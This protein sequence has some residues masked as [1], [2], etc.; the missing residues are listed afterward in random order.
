MVYI[1]SLPWSLTLTTNAHPHQ[2][3]R[4]TQNGTSSEAIE[5]LVDEPRLIFHHH[6]QL[7][8]N[9]EW[10]NRHRSSLRLQDR[11]VSHP[12]TSPSMICAPP[13]SKRRI[14]IIRRKIAADHGPGALGPS[15]SFANAHHF[16]RHYFCVWRQCVSL[17]WSNC[18]GPLDED[19]V[20]V[21][22]G[23]LAVGFAHLTQRHR[24]GLQ[25]PHHGL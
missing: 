9:P 18:G 25:R 4:H 24:D 16:S 17:D 14:R 7:R 2:S 12:A 23:W 6:L 21:L 8:H 10:R 11:L 20:Y 3:M 1:L 19:S 13:A 22:K 15:S 5:G